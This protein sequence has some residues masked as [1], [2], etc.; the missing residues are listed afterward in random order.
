M[1][2]GKVSIVHV[3]TGRTNPDV[4]AQSIL[5]LQLA[6]LPTLGADGFV[7]DAPDS[8][9]A[10]MDSSN[11]DRMKLWLQSPNAPKHIAAIS[12]PAGPA[13]Q[14]VAVI[15]DALRTAL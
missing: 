10:K 12:A 1:S 4:R 15:L 3:G 13:P 2:Q 7:S 9:D 8:H 11:G 6:L 5:A 14:P